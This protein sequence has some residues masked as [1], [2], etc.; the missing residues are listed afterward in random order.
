MVTIGLTI[1][2]AVVLLLL[3]FLGKNYLTYHIQMEWIKDKYSRKDWYD[4]ELP[5]YE[6]LLFNLKVWK[7][8]PLDEYNEKYK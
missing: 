1:I 6:H 5:S 3:I 4:T 2:L 8:I 7:Y